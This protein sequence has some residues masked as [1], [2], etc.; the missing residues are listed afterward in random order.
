M[1]GRIDENVGAGF[2]P[3]L[4]FEGIGDQGSGVREYVRA[5]FNPEIFI[6]IAEW[7]L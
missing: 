3:A 4:F 2:I 7:H 1:D 5:G 6:C